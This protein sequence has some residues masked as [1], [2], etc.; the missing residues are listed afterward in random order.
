MSDECTSAAAGFRQRRGAQARPAKTPR[1]ARSTSRRS[2]RCARCSAKGRAGR[3]LRSNTCTLIQDRYGHLSAAHL[4]ALAAEMKLAQTEVYGRDLL[5]AFRR[6]EGGETPPPPVTVRVCDSL[7]CADA[8]AEHLLDALPAKLGPR[9]A[10]RGAPVHGACDRAPVCAVGHVQ[11]MQASE[12]SVADAAAKTRTHTRMRRKS[13]SP[14]IGRP[15]DTGCWTIVFPAGDRARTRS[16]RSTNRLA[17]SRRR[18]IPH[19]PQVEVG[20]QS[21]LR[22]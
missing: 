1:A 18:R 12:Q 16:R 21:P 5:R 11:V 8:G 9:R 15:A 19:G 7:S 14:P 22:A 10:R 3:D 6:G 17:W 13:I 2:T 4:A 20:A